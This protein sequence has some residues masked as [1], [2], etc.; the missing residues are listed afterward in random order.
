MSTNAYKFLNNFLGISI[1][2]STN[3]FLT[4][5]LFLGDIDMAHYSENLHNS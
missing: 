5:I 4:N 2:V 1:K 3:W